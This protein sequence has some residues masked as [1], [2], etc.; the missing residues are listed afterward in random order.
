VILVSRPGPHPEE[1]KIDLPRPARNQQ[2]ELA[3]HATRRIKG[4]IKGHDPGP[5]VGRRS[6]EGTLEAAIFFAR[7]VGVGRRSVAPRIWSPVLLPSPTSVA[8]SYLWEAHAG[9]GTLARR[10]SHSLGGRN[11][12]RLLLGV[13]GLPLGSSPPAS[14][15]INERWVVARGFQEAAQRLRVPRQLLGCTDRGRYVL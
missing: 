7:L 5:P 4:P 13:I 9:D 12:L 3:R 2:W 14:R 1:F 10:L 15:V 6:H 11:G 8:R